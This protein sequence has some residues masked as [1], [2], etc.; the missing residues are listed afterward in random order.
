MNSII[1]LL[2]GTSLVLVSFSASADPVYVPT[3]TGGTW[4][5]GPNDLQSELEDSEV[6]GGVLNFDT[7]TDWY[8]QCGVKTTPIVVPAKAGFRAN[9]G[10]ELNITSF[11]WEGVVATMDDANKK[12]MTAEIS[13]GADVWEPRSLKVYALDAHPSY[14]YTLP[15][16]RLY[17]AAAAGTKTIPLKSIVLEEKAPALS[18][19]LCELAANLRVG[20]KSV[21]VTITYQHI[22][23]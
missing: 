5:F 11:A 14:E 12:L 13:D 20:V 1:K 7:G 6:D 23:E 19:A 16:G 18:L 15:D 2:A 22:G 3:T 17:I 8:A 9:V 4:T 10:I 21:R